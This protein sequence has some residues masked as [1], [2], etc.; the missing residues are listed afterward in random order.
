[1][2][3]T[4]ILDTKVLAQTYRD[5]PPPYECPVCHKSYRSL[6]GIL[7]HVGQFRSVTGIPRCQLGEVTPRRSPARTPGSPMSA[8]RRAPKREALTWAESQR[9]VEV[10]FQ[11]E[12]RRV[13]IDRDISLLD[14]YD[15]DQEEAVS[16][17]ESNRKAVLCK[18][19]LKRTRA[20]T[21]RGCKAQ[22][23]S[24][25]NKNKRRSKLKNQSQDAINSAPTLPVA[26]YEALE[27]TEFPEAPQRDA[28]YYRFVDQSAE[29]LDELVEYDMDEEDHQ[30]LVLINEERKNEGHTSVPQEAFELLLDRLEKECVFESHV[31]GPGN[32]ANPYNIDENAVCCICNDGECHNTN[33][34]LFCDMC[35]LAVH[36]ECYGVPYI[37]EG[38]WLCRRCLQ[39]PSCSVDCVLCPNKGGAFKQTLDG[40][41]AHVICAL[42]IPEVQFANTV[43]LEPIDGIHDVP[44]ARWKLMC[45]ICRKR[46]GAC[47]QCAKANCY[48]AF[49]VTCSQ[50]A[51]LYMKIEIVKGGEVRK[52]A[53]CD[54]HTPLSARKKLMESL[55]AEESEDSASEKEEE[56]HEVVSANGEGTKDGEVGGVDGEG[57]GKKTKSESKVVKRARKLLEEQQVAQAPVVNLPYVPQTR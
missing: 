27:I 4:P 48:T 55:D 43:F 44:A 20:D 24:T 35:N 21:P 52:T 7:Y 22:A 33:A 23:S 39:S 54:C 6:A 37:P 13:E 9:L 12:Y 41:W 15:Q 16:D 2:S 31:A 40:R 32:D 50:Q 53:Y 49:H 46:M 25:K 47:I 14:E 10:E 11:N 57:E 28:V 19:P 18:T 17:C 26:E 56:S 42:W 51:H 38:Q 1:M 29:E 30:W 5:Q 8:R 36:Q 3:E 45:Y 34:I